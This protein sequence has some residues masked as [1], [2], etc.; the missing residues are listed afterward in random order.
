M[1]DKKYIYGNILL[2][3]EVIDSLDDWNEGKEINLRL[4]D[5]VLD[6][7]WEIKDD[8]QIRLIDRGYNDGIDDRTTEIRTATNE[9]ELTFKDF[10]ELSDWI[11]KKVG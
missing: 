4:V 10:K 5:Q 6:Y 2:K 1:D 9:L 8:G 7:L 3:D 11:N